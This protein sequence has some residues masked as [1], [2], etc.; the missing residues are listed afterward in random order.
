MAKKLEKQFKIVAPGE[1]LDSERAVFTQ[2]GLDD[3]SGAVTGTFP[4]D[5]FVDVNDTPLEIDDYIWS[6][7]DADA[8]VVVIVDALF[9]GDIDHNLYMRVM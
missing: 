3:V 9:D 1:A 8:V 2:E 5:E 6:V 7:G 4:T